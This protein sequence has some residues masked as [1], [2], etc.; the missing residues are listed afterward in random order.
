[1]INIKMRSLNIPE[2]L[3]AI[4]YSITSL[5]R[6]TIILLQRSRQFSLCLESF[7][8]Q[9]FFVSYKWEKT[10]TIRDKKV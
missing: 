7:S 5:N 2:N 4:K 9:E 3:C 8:G 1:M 10:L 6:T